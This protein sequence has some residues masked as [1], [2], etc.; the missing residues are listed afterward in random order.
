MH[1]RGQLLGDSLEWAVAMAVTFFVL[2]M[3]VFITSSFKDRDVDTTQIDPYIYLARLHYSPTALYATDPTTGQPR[4]GHITLNEFTND[5]FQKN[6]IYHA[7][8]VGAQL[9]LYDESFAHIKGPIY[10]NEKLFTDYIGFA[11]QGVS[12]EGG[13]S[14]HEFLVPVTFDNK[15]GY[16]HMRIV[17]PNS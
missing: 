2:L 8:F 4:I 9:T 3:I 6:N 14:L 10:N 11:E 12:G 13:A 7:D 16:I 15:R 1:K 17:R 5:L